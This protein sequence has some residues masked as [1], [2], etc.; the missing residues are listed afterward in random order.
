MPKLPPRLFWKGSP[1]K[2]WPKTDGR[3]CLW[4]GPPGRPRA[5]AEGPPLFWKG[6]PGEPYSNMGGVCN[7]AREGKRLRGPH[8]FWKTE[9]EVGRDCFGK[10]TP[11]SHGPRQTAAFAY[12]RKAP[13][14]RGPR[15]KG[16]VYF[17]KGTPGRPRAE[18]K[19]LRLLWKGKAPADRGPRRK[20]RVCFGKGTL[21]GPYFK[22]GVA[23]NKAREGKRLRGP[24]FFK[25]GLSGSRGSGPWRS[26]RKRSWAGSPRSAPR[27]DTCRARSAF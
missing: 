11:E 12:A 9:P 27:G 24:C 20:G 13:A 14:D 5:E 1:G 2:P 3:L 15:R 10:E 19:G 23:C 25:A 17:G 26:C 21:A 8:L 22:A 6:S 4:K 16:R 18:T 7:K